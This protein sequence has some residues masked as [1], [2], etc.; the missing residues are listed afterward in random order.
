M[1]LAG[2]SNPQQPNRRN[3]DAASPNLTESACKCMHSR[4]R[5]FVTRTGVLI[6]MDH[7]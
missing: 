5:L 4:S 2:T 1:E 3:N 6:V 7:E